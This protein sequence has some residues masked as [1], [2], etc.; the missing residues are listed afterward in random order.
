MPSF[1]TNRTSRSASTFSSGLP[2]TAMQSAASP[3]LMSP[4][5]IGERLGL[6]V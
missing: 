5:V 1:I 3:G 2:A 4:R 6:G